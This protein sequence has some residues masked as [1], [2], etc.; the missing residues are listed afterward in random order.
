MQKLLTTPEAAA[1]LGFNPRT[2]EN[3]RVKGIGPKFIQPTKRSY[4]RYA[5]EDLEAWKEENK[6]KNTSV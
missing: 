1:L 2:L 6:R 4:V 5:P 3:W